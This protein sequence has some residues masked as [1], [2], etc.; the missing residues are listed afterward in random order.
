MAAHICAEG[1]REWLGV[2]LRVLG[3]KCGDDFLVLE[4]AQRA[5]R[6]DESAAWSDVLA[7]LMQQRALL[8]GRRFDMAR[9]EDPFQM[10]RAA[11][12]A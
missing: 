4:M 1:V 11:P 3:E 12:R 10:R 8:L 7:E 2:K 5:G 9:R 6:I